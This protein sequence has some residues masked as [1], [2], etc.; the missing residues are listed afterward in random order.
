MSRKKKIDVQQSERDIVNVAGNLNLNGGILQVEKLFVGDQDQLDGKIQEAEQQ[1]LSLQFS[2]SYFDAVR[3]NFADKPLLERAL[4]DDL[5]QQVNKRR[6]VLLTGQPGSGK[7]CCFLQLSKYCSPV[8]ISLRD[9]SPVFLLGYLINKIRISRNE[10]LIRIQDIETGL[11]ILETELQE[12]KTVFFIDDLEVDYSFAM[13]LMALNKGDNLF[14]Y[15]SRN[16]KELEPSGI[17]PFHLPA[18]SQEE[19]KAFLHLQGITLNVLEFTELYQASAGNPLY[20]FYFSK[21]QIK[22]LPPDIQSYHQSIWARLDQQAKECLIFCSLSYQPLLVEDLAKL[23]NETPVAVVDRMVAFSGLLTN[24]DG[25]LTVFHPVFKEF[26]L[27][28]IGSDGL[29]SAYKKQLAEFYL[30]GNNYLNASVLLVDEDPVRFN[31]FGEFCIAPVISLGDLPLAI[32]FIETLLQF[33]KTGLREGYLRYHLS[34]IYRYL[35]REQEAS[36]ELEKAIALFGK[37]RNK[38]WLLTAQMIKAIDLV[39][40][41]QKEE[42]LQLADSIMAKTTKYGNTFHARALVNLTKIYMDLSE[43][44]KAADAGKQAFDLFEQMNEPAGMIASLANLASSLTQLEDH[45][46]LAEK[47]ALKI[48]SLPEDAAEFGLRMIALNILTSV[49]RKKKDFTPAKQYGEEAIRLCKQHQLPDKV[50]LNLINYGNIIR[51]EGNLEDAVK[52]Y[53]EALVL[54]NEIGLKKEESRIYWILTSLYRQKEEMELSLVYADK[55]IAAAQQANHTYGMARTLEEKAK[56]L[57]V[58]D[59]DAEAA[60]A[61]EK[62]G[63]IFSSITQYSKDARQCFLQAIDIYFKTGNLEKGN[64]LLAESIIDRPQ[65]N[66]GELEDLMMGDGPHNDHA[67]IHNSFFQLAKKY[68]SENFCENAIRK[69]LVYA[70]Y[71]HRNPS[72]SKGPYN[73]VLLQ[74]AM[75]TPINRFAKTILAILLD[76]SR[77]L[78]NEEA[79]AP[80]IKILCNSLN[81]LYYRETSELAVFTSAIIPKLNLQ[82]LAFKT[83]VLTKKMALVLV[84]FLFAAP[85]MIDLPET[86]SSNSYS[87]MLMNRRDIEEEG[88]SLDLAEEFSDDIQ[89]LQMRTNHGRTI[90]TLLINSDYENCADLTAFPDNKCLMYCLGILIISITSHYAGIAIKS[91]RRDTKPV[92][93]KL[94]FFFDYTNLEDL[95]TLNKAFE[96]DIKKI[97]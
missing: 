10:S 66:A 89:T 82:L 70:G 17:H 87:A 62:S 58:M 57:Y 18:L 79:L 83:D 30:S 20:L 65:D 34:Y 46:D 28:R 42:G 51:D 61:Y 49:N 6:Q 1:T 33:P 9:R 92:T 47:Y 26:I 27:K 37:L 5:W 4:L 64:Q 71:C 96:V 36:E 93:R 91:I 52:I 50:I 86:S 60:D 8:Y 59:R 22:P 41:G 84:L 75:A 56:T 21:F 29:L 19:A 76:Q 3:K 43:F 95:K 35:Y 45:Q 2:I 54:I 12:T 40:N 88:A 38:R 39:E 85:E 97:N 63:R 23:W 44:N 11:A 81:G 72:T 15:A 74:L 32:R 48:L 31:E 16:E 78:T 73:E 13:R 53:D 14:L 24:Q 69:F 94:A 7:T 55:A 25:K 77:E 80:I 90:D 67:T 68:Q